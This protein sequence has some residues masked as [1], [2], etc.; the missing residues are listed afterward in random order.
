MQGLATR[1]YWGAAATER[2]ILYRGAG[3]T[4]AQQYIS[5]ETEDGDVDALAREGQ[6]AVLDTHAA[7]HITHDMLHPPPAFV[8]PSRTHAYT[9]PLS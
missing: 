2:A 1:A 5:I 6:Q 4:S 9:Q 7:T 3:S 8:R